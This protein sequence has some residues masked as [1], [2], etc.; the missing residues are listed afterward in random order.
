M[1]VLYN[2]FNNKIIDNNIY[3]KMKLYNKVY[4]LL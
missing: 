4:V 1:N 2:I 3:F